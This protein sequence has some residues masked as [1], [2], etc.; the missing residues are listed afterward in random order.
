[1]RLTILALAFGATFSIN[2]TAQT[3]VFT[4]D[5]QSG[6]PA[7]WTLINNDNNTPAMTVQEYDTAAWIPKMDPDDSSNF[8]ASSTS[9]F[10]PAGTANRWL[11]SPAITLGAFGN[12]MTYDVK[13]HDPSFPDDYM[14]LVSKT[15]TNIADFTDT[16]A[17]VQQELASWIKRPIDLTAKGLDGET[18]HLAF[19][20][21]TEDGFKLYVD[22]IEVTKDDPAQLTESNLVQLKVATL[23]NGLYEVSANQAILKRVV[24]TTS[25]RV[26]S[27]NGQSTVDLRSM[28]AGVY[29]IE[30]ST[31]LGRKTLQVQKF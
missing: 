13:S 10:S 9:F 6:I 12:A 26:V 24:Y 16:I 14:I 25:G 21:V 31:E 22:N 29:F 23:A 7:T 28:E 20:I 11:I 3:T 18:I 1:M 19:V 15:G 8:C 4:E 2:A 5:F 17:Y 27:E 30:V